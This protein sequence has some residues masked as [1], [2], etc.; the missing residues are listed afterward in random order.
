MVAWSLM[1]KKH[2]RSENKT[3]LIHS[4]VG[5]LLLKLFYYLLIT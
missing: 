4:L 1:F 2:S 3:K 5:F